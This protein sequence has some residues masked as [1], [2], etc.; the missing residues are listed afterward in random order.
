[1]TRQ[2]AIWA[3]IA[4]VISG[5]A[6]QGKTPPAPVVVGERVTP[7][8][9]PLSAAQVDRQDRVSEQHA[10]REE[11]AQRTRPLLSQL[12]YRGEGIDVSLAGLS[13]DGRYAVLTLRG[14]GTDVQVRAAYRR[15]LRQFGDSGRGYVT[16]V[17]P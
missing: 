1:M 14:A 2:L 4:A 7:A 10:A 11:H 17:L 6:G 16:Q 12:P 8:A 15:V 3:A 9:P 5:C 13:A